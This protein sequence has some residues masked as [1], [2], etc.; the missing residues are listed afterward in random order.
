MRIFLSS[1]T[2]IQGRQPLHHLRRYDFH[3]FALWRRRRLVRLE[4]RCELLGGLLRALDQLRLVAVDRVG[5]DQLSLVM[6]R[7]QRHRAAAPGPAGCPAPAAPSR[8]VSGW[9]GRCRARCRSTSRSIS[10][11]TWRR[12]RARARSSGSGKLR[13]ATSTTPS[14]S[15]CRR[16]PP[17]AASRV[18]RA[19][20]AQ[21]VGA[22]RDRRRRPSLPNRRTTSTCPGSRS[23]AVKRMPCMRSTRPTIWPTRPKPA[24]DHRRVGVEDRVVDRRLLA[25]RRRGI[26][27]FSTGREQQR[28]RRHRQRH[29]QRRDRGLRWRR[30]RRPPTAAPNSTKLN[31]LPCGR[32]RAKRSGVD[33]RSLAAR[34][35]RARSR[36]RS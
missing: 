14:A 4:Q 15:P 2:M 19:G 32:A 3:R 7:E 30:A 17:P 35:G 5:R 9:N 36:S 28:R 21:Q 34:C 26:S 20:G 8:T 31:S 11:C 13:R 22:R 6:L 27:S 16:S 33:A 10:R 23:S 18:S 24:D 1:I 29:H 25:C 12:L